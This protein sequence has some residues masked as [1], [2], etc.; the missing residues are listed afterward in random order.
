MRLRTHDALPPPRRVIVASN[1]APVTIVYLIDK[2]GTGGVASHLRQVLLHLDRKRF[3]PVIV[4]L[5]GREARRYDPEGH[6]RMVSAYRE[7]G[8][9]VEILTLECIYSPRHLG[10]YWRLLRL[11]RECRPAIL[12]MYLF[13]STLAGTLAGLLA[14]VPRL[15]ASRRESGSWWM[16][17]RHRRALSLGHRFHHAVVANST[18]IARE[19]RELESVPADRVHVIFNGVD[20]ESVT[21]PGDAIDPSH[22]A[23]TGDGPVVGMV[24][25][26]VPVK[27]HENVL[28]AAMQVHQKRPDARFVL[29]GDGPLRNKLETRAQ[30]LGLDD[31]VRFV[32]REPAGWW[33][34]IFDIAVQSSLSEG[35]S[36]VV[37][38][39]MAAGKPMVVTAVG[40][41]VDILEHGR[42]ALLVPPE[43]PDA[44][45]REILA[46]LADPERAAVMGNAARDEVASKY[47]ARAMVEHMQ[48]L[49]DSV[50]GDPGA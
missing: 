35:G 15:V 5:A 23:L 1:R 50:I 12:H 13:S 38:E 11:L 49:Y 25:N 28:A 36:N 39:Y 47:T 26:L 31:A 46:L 9:R 41:N 37:L 27:G 8:A 33:L 16:L 45:A 10:Q 4:C 48:A 22:P 7:L 40:A 18:E 19:L 14:R 44:M 43:D 20:L 6:D 3:T 32:G 30:S 2:I 29:I 24:G 21:G 17:P 34:P 42:T